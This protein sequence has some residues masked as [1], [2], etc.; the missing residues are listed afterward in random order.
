MEHHLELKSISRNQQISGKAEKILSPQ[1]SQ[2]KKVGDRL[3]SEKFNLSY[4][5]LHH[6]I[7]KSV[8]NILPKSLGNHLKQRVEGKAT[9]D[10]ELV[11]Y[12]SNLP[13]Y[14]ERRENFQEKALSFGVL[15]WGR[16]EKWQYDHKQIPN[17]SGRHS[18]SSSNSSSLF[19]TDESSTHSSGE[20]FSEGVKFFGG[21]AGKFQDLN[22]P[23]GTPFSGQQRFIKTNQ[24]S[25][26][27]QSEIKLEK[28]KINSSNPKA[29]AEMRTSTNLENCEMA[30]CSKGK[31]KIQDGDFAERKEG[32]KEP[33]PIIIFKECPKKY[34]TA[35][36]HSPRDLPKNG[37]SGL[38]Q[39][40][41]SSAA[42]GSTEAPRRSFSERS[43]STKVHSAKLYSGIPHSCA[44][45][46][47]VDSK[48]KNPE[49]KKPTIVPTNS[50]AREPSE[51][52][53]LKKGTVAAAKVRNSSPTRR[54][55]IS[56]SRI[57]RSS[58]SKD[59]MA[60]PPLSAS[61]VDTKSGPDRAMAACMD[62]YSDG[63]N[64]TSRARSSPL[65]R[66]LDPLLKPKAGNS[67][68][69]PEPLQKD[70]TSIDRSCLS[71]KEQL[72]SSNSRSGKV[73]L[74][75][76]SFDGDKDILAAT[77][78]KSTIGKDDYSW[79]Y[80]FFTI[81]E[82][83]KKNRSWINQGQ[84]GKGHGYIPNVVAQM[85]V[86]DSQFSS[87]TI[88]NSTKQFSLRE[89]VLFAV[90]L[91][92]ADEQ[93]SNIQP[94][95]ELAAMVVK[96]PKENTGSSIKD[97]QQSSYFND[98][99]ASV[100]NGNSPDVKCQPVWEE[101][102]QNQPF[103]G[104]QDHF[105]TKV[106]LPSGVHSL[107]NKGEPSRLLER[108]KSGGSCDCGGWDMGCKLRVLVNQN[109]HR[110][111]PSPPTTDRFELFSLEGVEADEPIFSMS[112]FKDGIYSAEFS[113]PLSLLQAFSI[114]IAVL[115]SRTQPSEMSNPS[116][117]RSD[118]IIKAPN[119][120][121]GEAAARLCLISTPFS[122]G[123]SLDSHNE[124][125]HIIKHRL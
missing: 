83:K 113:S 37:H 38:S 26:Q 123:E 35:V 98:L 70:S 124:A 119:Q 8:D 102:V 82:V 117:E 11:K 12:M 6:E 9:E 122:S 95:D 58:S 59:G 114:C 65:R 105:I 49:E 47:D 57:I 100:S 108:W 53:D 4:A 109:Q 111:K 97:E 46:C 72:D 115:N 67:H 78:R 55:S 16:L 110:K 77:M 13:S 22:A 90:D 106:I 112:S 87:L 29:S 14:L 56:M 50:T 62:S 41:G 93:T 107:P 63:Q 48:S 101:N 85:K 32:S 121:Q 1:V 60:I 17:K 36:A 34:R 23:S 31:M 64:A 73:K 103:A 24:S 33:N 42:R 99:S 5:D 25:C 7:T 15:D 40:P 30:S 39:L 75:L 86:S 52:S 61:H 80:T 28:C 19:S 45:P 69:F 81:S 21:N 92:Q 84:K 104:S 20:G 91:R 96:I 66:L 74:D 120:V 79:I 10:E 68:Q 43:N 44:L 18:S 118:G 116:E 89:F 3:K 27:I 76:S 94:N 2:S 51:G 71:S 125:S 88:C 54:F